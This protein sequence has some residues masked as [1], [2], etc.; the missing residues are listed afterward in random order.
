MKLDSICTIR[1]NNTSVE[2]FIYTTNTNYTLT[3]VEE[4]KSYYVNVVAQFKPNNGLE[5]EIV[6]YKPTEIIIR[7]KT[8]IVF[9]ASKLI[10]GLNHIVLIL[11]FV[12]GLISVGLLCKK[13]RENKEPYYVPKTYME[14]EM[15]SIASG[16]NVGKYE[17]PVDLDSTISSTH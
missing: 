16:G 17:R 1:P 3:N 7:S 8:S 5:D 13:C 4:D 12:V 2:K 14:Y 15:T 10:K 9:I 11:S 6:P